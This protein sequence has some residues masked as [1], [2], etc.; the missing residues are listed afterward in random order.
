MVHI[1]KWKDRKNEISCYLPEDAVPDKNAVAELHQMTAMEETL[2]RLTAVSGFFETNTPQ[3]KKL[4]LTPDFHKGAGIPIGTVMMTKGFV[5]PQAMG[6]DINCGMRFYTT[7]LSEEK[8]RQKLPE[9]AKKIR[10]VFFEGGRQIPMTGRQREALFRYGLEGI[11]ETYRDSDRRGLWQYFQPEIQERWL[12]RTV[13]RGS[14]KTAD[15]EGLGTVN[16]LILTIGF[17]F[18]IPFSQLFIRKKID[19]GKFLI[20]YFSSSLINIVVYNTIDF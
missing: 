12:D 18:I 4:I 2:E 5:V 9:L 20:R 14:I 13:F 7:D 11:L 19:L 1:I 16:K 17:D 8:I 6:N 3:I 10:H 15:A